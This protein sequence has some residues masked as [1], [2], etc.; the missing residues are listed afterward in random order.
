MNKLS[1]SQS[2]PEDIQNEKSLKVAASVRAVLYGDCKTISEAF[3][4]DKKI[5]DKSADKI[6]RNA[7]FMAGDFSRT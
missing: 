1:K 6:S 2:S 5:L 7:G 4:K 3:E